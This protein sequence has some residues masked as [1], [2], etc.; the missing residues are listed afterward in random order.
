MTKYL[1]YPALI[2]SIFCCTVFLAQAATIEE[3]LSL[4][5]EAAK[6]TDQDAVELYKAVR[7]ALLPDGR[8]EVQTTIV[9]LLRTYWSMDNYGD[10]EIP[11]DSVR[12]ELT[13]SM[14]RTFMANGK[15]VDTTPN[16]FNRITPDAVALAPDYTSLQDMVVTHL[17]LEP[18]AITY[19]DYTIR[20]RKPLGEVFS[21]TAL[22]GG[23]NPVLRQEFAIEVPAGAKLQIKEGNG[24][25][26]AQKSTTAGVDRYFWRM[27]KLPAAWAPDAEPFASRFRPRV[28]FSNAANWDAVLRP[29]VS[30]IA[31]D[32]SVTPEM[33]RIVGNEFGDELSAESRVLAIQTYLRERFNRIE[34]GYPLFKR[35]LRPAAQVFES[36]YG[37]TLDL[38]VLFAA[39]ARA[40]GLTADVAL[41]FPNPPDVPSLE[42]F[43]EALV[44]VQTDGGERLFDVTKPPKECL[45]ERLGDAQILRLKPGASLTLAPVPWADQP[46]FSELLVTWD[47]KSDSSSSGEGVWRFGGA[48]NHLGKMRDGKLDELLTDMLKGFWK[49]IIVEDVSVRTMS[50][51]E[52]E[53]AFH[54]RL[55]QA[56]DTASGV[57]TLSLPDNKAYTSAVLPKNLDFAES[58]RPVPLFL[59][60]IGDWHVKLRI[61]Y[62]DEWKTIHLP[63]EVNVQNAQ[64]SFAQ[65]VQTEGKAITVERRM[66]FSE[67]AIPP[68]RWGEF[69]QIVQPASNVNVNAVVFE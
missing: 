56:G 42:D 51:R 61:E 9:R 40:A 3:I 52:S 13:V 46:T 39:L 35:T 36:G 43:S 63:V 38:A 8:R 24:V 1:I 32:T 14:S 53:L 62:P 16:G 44:I 18:G 21:G 11:Y 58:K 4:K 34:H 20:D 49:G 57:R 29:L 30:A 31:A 10:P 6:Y 12:Q 68:E 50:P 54:M 23:R 37:H 19:L 2:L 60:A 67:R 59:R 26:A 33:R 28:S 64:G 25:P 27:D 48:L 47:L 5:S 41:V 69:Q 22:F 17:G 65:T 45:R 55:P 7:Y 66:H 15:I